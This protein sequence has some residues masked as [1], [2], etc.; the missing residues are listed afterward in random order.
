MVPNLSL[1]TN[2][3]PL[4]QSHAPSLGFRQ[5]ADPEPSIHLPRDLLLGCCWPKATHGP[6]IMAAHG[7]HMEERRVMHMITI[8]IWLFIQ[9]AWLQRVGDL[10]Q[11]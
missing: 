3:I 4:L 7:P 8:M 1:K 10:R 2:K 11:L 5:P 9:R 6:P